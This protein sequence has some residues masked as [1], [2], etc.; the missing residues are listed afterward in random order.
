[1]SLDALRKL[2]AQTQ[3]ALMMELAQVTQELMSLEQRCEALDARLQS[4][5]AAWRRQAAQGMTAQALLEW[6]GRLAS[7]Q[8]SLRRARGA[9]DRLTGLWAET[10]ARLVEATRARKVLDRLDERRRAESDAV[11]LRREQRATDETTGRRL[12]VKRDS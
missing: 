6:E 8:A 11:T 7:Q 2:R 9:I 1:M 3:E 4:D 5:A 12:F 10:Q